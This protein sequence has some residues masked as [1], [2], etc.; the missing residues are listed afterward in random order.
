MF[1][2]IALI[3]FVWATHQVSFAQQVSRN[4]GSRTA[5]ASKVADSYYV[6]GASK[7]W[8]HTTNT[9]TTVKEWQGNAWVDTPVQ[10]I[11]Q[12]SRAITLVDG[13]QISYEKGQ[14]IVVQTNGNKQEYTLD[15]PESKE[16]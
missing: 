13:R 1:K 16:K 8:I 15:V 11:E 2:I 7:F 10:T 9:E 12:S 5:Q 14:K 3:C 4:L 6:N